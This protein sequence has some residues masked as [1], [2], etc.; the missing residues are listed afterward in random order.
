MKEFDKNFRIAVQQLL[1]EK[2]EKKDDKPADAP[3]PVSTAKAKD[4]I[5]WS[6]SRGGWSKVITG[7]RDEADYDSVINSSLASSG[8][9]KNLMMKLQ[10]TRM[11][12]SS[13]IQAAYDILVQAVKNP[14]MSEAYGNPTTDSSGILVPVI[15]ETADK[16]ADDYMSPR[17]ATAFIHLTLIGAYN[18]GFMPNVGKLKLITPEPDGQIRIVTN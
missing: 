12:K 17:N 4:L 13:G 7:A 14:A 18:A 11:S 2:D 3:A 10:V 1:K 15:V 6:P 16:D 8:K 5:S 9:A